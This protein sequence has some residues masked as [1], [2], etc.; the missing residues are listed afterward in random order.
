GIIL[1]VLWVVGGEY[2][3]EKRR[4]GSMLSF[5]GERMGIMVIV[6][7]FIG[8]GLGVWM[9]VGGGDYLSRFLKVG[10]IVGLG[11]GILIVGA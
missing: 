7:G 1:V 11:I 6:Y 10:R 9:V 5:N 2:V 4:V 8:S 3:G